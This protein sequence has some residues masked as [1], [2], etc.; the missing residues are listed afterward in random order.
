MNGP[1][2]AGE[3]WAVWAQGCTVCVFLGVVPPGAGRV[4]A[5]D[6]VN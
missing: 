6:D 3:V 5:V 2:S 1:S 4:V